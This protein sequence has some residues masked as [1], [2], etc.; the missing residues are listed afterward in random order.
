VHV[1]A[2]GAL[3]AA[4]AALGLALAFRAADRAGL[5]RGA[6]TAFLVA[7]FGGAFVAA[8]FAAAQ[9]DGEPTSVECL[10]RTGGSSG[11]AVPAALLLGFAAASLLRLPVGRLLDVACAGAAPGLAVARLG[12]IA[13][14]CCGGNAIRA[15][16]LR[17][18]VDA[19]GCP[20]R[21]PVPV[22]EAVVLAAASP[23]LWRRAPTARPGATAAAFLVVWG[24][25]RLS[26]T[27]LRADAGVV[28]TA[29]A[30]ACVLVGAAVLVSAA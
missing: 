2:Y 24:A 13:A 8:K 7:G 30:A 9:I 22:Y 5:A 27:L 10:L 12:C 23:F 29:A 6:S 3:H 11:L 16:W 18:L 17:S 19:V 26:M 4:G 14:G 25:L 21:Q 20:P 28:E 15:A 1:S